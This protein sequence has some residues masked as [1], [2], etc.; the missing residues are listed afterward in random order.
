AMYWHRCPVLELI[1]SMRPADWYCSPD[2]PRPLVDSIH[3]NVEIV[4]ALAHLANEY[5]NAPTRMLY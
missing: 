4:S 2:S 3:A 5:A 1:T